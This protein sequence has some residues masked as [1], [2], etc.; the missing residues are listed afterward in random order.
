MTSL[1]RFFIERPKLVNLIMVL[2]ILLGL[3]SLQISRYEVTPHID[4]GVVT[5][6]TTKAGA[7][8]EE[9]ELGISLVLEEE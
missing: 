6:T 9:V 1:V 8:P 7:G 2:V 3:M 4:M 5:V